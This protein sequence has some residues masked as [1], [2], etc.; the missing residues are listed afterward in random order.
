[1]IRKNSS[2]LLPCGQQGEFGQFEAV[3]IHQSSNAAGEEDVSQRRVLV[4]PH[5]GPHGTFVT[6]FQPLYL[7]FALQGYVVLLGTYP[8]LVSPSFPTLTV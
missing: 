3:V 7:F 1:V 6:D 4:L 2:L 5:G 8:W